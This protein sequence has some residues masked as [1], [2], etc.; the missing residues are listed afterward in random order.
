MYKR[1][2]EEFRNH[3]R[4]VHTVPTNSRPYMWFYVFVDKDKIYIEP[5]HHN[6]PKSNVKKR[7][8]SEKEC[9]DILAIYHRRLAGERVYDEAKD[10]TH[11]QVYWYGIFSDMNL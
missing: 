5:G 10:C 11:S 6:F 1:I 8:L 7:L 9:N 4:D 2:V 3:P